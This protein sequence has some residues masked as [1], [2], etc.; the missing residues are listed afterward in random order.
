[1]GRRRKTESHGMR[2][3]LPRVFGPGMVPV[4]FM[5]IFIQC[6]SYLVRREGVASTSFEALCSTPSHTVLT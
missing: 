2:F 4:R 1:M 5:V 3:R 6:E